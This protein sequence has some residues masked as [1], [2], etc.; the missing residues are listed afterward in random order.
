MRESDKQRLLEWMQKYCC[1]H[2]KART[3]ENIL[4]YI[5]IPGKHGL[6]KDRYLQELLSELRHDGKVF[7]SSSLGYWYFDAESADAREIKSAILATEEAKR[8]AMSVITGIDKQLNLLRS[9]IL[10]VSGSQ[11]KLEF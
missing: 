9:K 5:I 11:G 8:R 1:G 2:K 3:R 7:S 4:P 6:S 10:V